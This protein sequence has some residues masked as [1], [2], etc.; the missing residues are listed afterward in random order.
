METIL[1][2]GFLFISHLAIRGIFWG[3]S[4][5]LILLNTKKVTLVFVCDQIRV[6]YNE[7]QEEGVECFERAA[8]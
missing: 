7:E 4:A 3:Y 8:L 2:G 6:R 5:E 1:L